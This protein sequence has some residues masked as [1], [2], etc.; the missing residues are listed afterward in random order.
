MIQNKTDKILQH[1]P[2]LSEVTAVQ[3]EKILLSPIFHWT[4]SGIYQRLDKSLEIFS[5]NVMQ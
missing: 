4:L 1:Q 2:E 3:G 5:G